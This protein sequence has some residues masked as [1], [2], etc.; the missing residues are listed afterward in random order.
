MTSVC[1]LLVGAEGDL[2]TYIESQCPIAIF[3]YKLDPVLGWLVRYKFVPQ[4]FASMRC[5]AVL[6]VNQTIYIGS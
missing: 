6:R 3:S 4:D 5:C 2:I 1:M